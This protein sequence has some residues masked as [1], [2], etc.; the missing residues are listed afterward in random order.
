MLQWHFHLMAAV[1]TLVYTAGMEP[2][3]AI[4]LQVDHDGACCEGCVCPWVAP[5]PPPLPLLPLQVP[6]HETREEPSPPPAPVEPT[7]GSCASWCPFHTADWD[8]KCKAYQPCRGCVEC[9][10]AECEPWC[11]RP[12]DT[13]VGLPNTDWYTKCT[14]FPSCRGCLECL[15]PPSPPPGPTDCTTETVAVAFVASGDVSDYDQSVQDAIALAFATEAGVDRRAATL[16][17]TL[18]GEPASVLISATLEVPEGNGE[19]V[20]HAFLT[21][22]L[23]SVSTLEAVLAQYGVAIEVVRITDQGTLDMCT[24]VEIPLI[25]DYTD[26]GDDDGDNHTD[27]GPVGDDDANDGVLEPRAPLAS[28]APDASPS[29]APD[30]L[31]PS[32]SRAAEPARPSTDPGMRPVDDPSAVN[33]AEPSPTPSTNPGMSW[34]DPAVNPVVN[35]ADPSSSQHARAPTPLA[36][37]SPYPGDGGGG[38]EDDGGG[39]AGGGDDGEDGGDGGGGDGEGDDGDGE[40]GE[41]GGDSG[42]GD[43]GRGEGGSGE[44]GGGEGGGGGGGGNGGGGGGNGGDSKGGDGKGGDG[45]GGGGNGGGGGD[46]DDGDGDGGGGVG[47]GGKIGG[48]GGGGGGGDGDG[49]GGGGGNG[50]GG[51]SGGGNGNGNGGGGG[52]GHA[53]RGG[54]DGHAPSLSPDPSPSPSPDPSPSPSPDPSASPSPDLLPPLYEECTDRAGSWVPCPAMTTERRV[55]ASVGLP[56]HREDAHEDAHASVRLAPHHEDAHEDAAPPARSPQSQTLNITLNTVE[57]EMIERLQ[58]EVEK[59]RGARRGARPRRATSASAAHPTSRVRPLS[60]P[61][62]RSGD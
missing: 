49:G 44:G 17:A 37:P 45:N 46:G 8:T 47:G 51:G 61:V 36:S 9:P 28:G 53:R 50:N 25:D 6:S 13:T 59:L 11:T 57:A 7:D 18:S 3:Y 62:V 14:A 60:M 26:D 4:V 55:R 29:G 42:G 10:A 22:M 35:P 30:A 12:A 40:V 1:F 52:G 31:A 33:P 34:P 56:P 32:A 27:V 23:A 5:S 19:Q 38:G 54:G 24:D 21:G 41:G 16:S 20:V 2:K 39:G 15:T 43:G 48:G 58:R